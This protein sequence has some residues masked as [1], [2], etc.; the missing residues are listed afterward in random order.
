MAFII[1]LILTILVFMLLFLRSYRK[2]VFFLLACVSF[3]VM[4]ACFYIF[5]VKTA[6][7]MSSQRRLSYAP[8]FIITFCRNIVITKDLH[9]VLYTISRNFTA[10]ALLL[11]AIQRNFYL[12]RYFQRH[13]WCYA[14]VTVPIAVNTVLF[15][16]CVMNSLFAYRYAL[17]TLLSTIGFVVLTLYL[18]AALAIHVW[19]YASASL[20]WYRKQYLFTIFDTASF[21]VLYAFFAFLDPTVIY[22]DYARVFIYS[23]FLR[24]YSISSVTKWILLLSLGI[25]TAVVTL[26]YS[27][28]ASKAVYDRENLEM[29]ISNQSRSNPVAISLVIHG[30]KKQILEQNILGKSLSQNLASTAP[31]LERACVQ[32]ESLQTINAEM[33]RKMDYLYR[34][35]Q[36][37][38][39]VLN[40][41]PVANLIA[42]LRARLRDKYPADSIHYE[43]DEAEVLC[44][45]NLMSEALLNIVCNAYESVPTERS[46]SI[47]FLVQ[48]LRANIAFIIRDNGRGI[49]KEV[50]NKVF[51]PFTTSKTTERSWGL[52][53]CFAYQIVKKHLG[54][55]YFESSTEGTT[56]YITLPKYTK[57]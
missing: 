28:S 3:L 53:L 46:P 54:N 12:R 45:A 8:Q 42:G 4:F 41:M 1:F 27:W 44:E 26:F 33:F 40:K 21:M 57:E 22:Q 19:E 36:N 18:F 9:A 38:D 16:P 48:D 23:S 10:L 20:S 7:F 56:F 24:L 50:G 14:A 52:G 34:S 55:I 17:Q 6:V 32:A 11:D 51:L 35:F 37:K 30:L 15:L 43:I 31:D 25:V 13:F 2:T 47:D 49:P 5:C 39:I 29:T